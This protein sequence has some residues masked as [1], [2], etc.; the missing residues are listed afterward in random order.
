MTLAAVLAAGGLGAVLFGLWSSRQR[1]DRD[2]T[3]LRSR[4]RALDALERI[5]R[6]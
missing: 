5:Q 4:R 6:R 1:P 2:V 3:Q